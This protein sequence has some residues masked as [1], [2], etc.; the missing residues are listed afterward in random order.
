VQRSSNGVRCKSVDDNSSKE[1][2]L[3]KADRIKTTEEEP[4]IRI[5]L[6]PYM[7][8]HLSLEE[9]ARKSADLGYEWIELSPRDNSDHHAAAPG[10]LRLKPVGVA[11]RSAF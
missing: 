6:D 2:V 7:H 10:S 1:G 11:G 5:A 4:P 8:R 9:L 3:W